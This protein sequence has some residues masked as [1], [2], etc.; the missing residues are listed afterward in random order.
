MPRSVRR[1]HF[2]RNDQHQRRR[3][4]GIASPWNVTAAGGYRNDPVSQT[5]PRLGAE[6]F[7]LAHG[8]PLGA[9]KAFDIGLCCLQ[10]LQILRLHLRV[11]LFNLFPADPKPLPDTLVKL[12]VVLCQGFVPVGTDVIYDRCD[13]VSQR[14]AVLRRPLFCFFDNSSFYLIPLLFPYFITIL[15]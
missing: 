3:I 10:I 4:Q 12:L 13:G 8:A 5:D 11:G 15:S 2:G 6:I 9:G 14:P 7:Q 1:R